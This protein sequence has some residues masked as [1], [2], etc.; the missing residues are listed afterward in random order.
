[1]PAHL[2]FCCNQQVLKNKMAQN[3]LF[4]LKN[5][6]RLTHDDKKLQAFSPLMD[7]RST[8]LPSTLIILFSMAVKLMRL[9]IFPPLHLLKKLAVQEH[10][11]LCMK[12]NT[13][14]S[15]GLARG[16]SVDNAVAVVDE[17]R[18]LK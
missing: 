9:W 11:V 10:L 2:Y 12:L 13:L 7:L 14:R 3:N 5:R 15:K 16:G 1:M 17:Y 4:V 18:I 8:L 6:S